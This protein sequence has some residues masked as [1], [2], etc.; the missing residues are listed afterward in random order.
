[1]KVKLVK[2]PEKLFFVKVNSVDTDV[3]TVIEVKSKRELE[4]LALLYELKAIFDHPEFYFI[5]VEGILY[6]SRKRKR[7]SKRSPLHYV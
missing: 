6:V 5:V 7:K 1:M 4:E 2:K 3:D